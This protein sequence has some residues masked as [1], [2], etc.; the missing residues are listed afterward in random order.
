MIRFIHCADICLDAPLGIGDAKK[1]AIRRDE[2]RSSFSKVLSEAAENCVSFVLISGGLFD[3]N[4]VSKTTVDFLCAEFSRS[5][6]IKFIIAPGK[7]DYYGEDSIYRTAAFPENVHIFNKE[8][9]STL[10]FDI[11]DDRVSVHGCAKASPTAVCS[12]ERFRIPSS[13]DINILVSEALI[14]PENTGALTAQKLEAAGFD[15]CALSHP[16]A[17]VG[18][19]DEGDMWY[20]Y[21]GA[22]ES[23]SFEGMNDGGY[24]LVDAQKNG[25]D[26]TCKAKVVRV[27]N[28]KY[29]NES[30]SVSGALS[31]DEVVSTVEKSLEGIKDSVDSN[32]VLA[33]TVK[34]NTA[35]D[36]RDFTA[37][38]SELE[39]F[40]KAF[41]ASVTDE[42]VPLYN[43]EYLSEDPTIKGALYN[44]LR[45]AICSD[46]AQV[47]RNAI[48]ALRAGL[49]ALDNKALSVK[50]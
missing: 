35:P 36:V 19:F 30:I 14:T 31:T 41:I 27:T 22:P 37:K 2:M 25:K 15:Y 18:V 7:L 39:V 45:P 48:N 24:V 34:G 1:A 12:V 26:F 32:T 47:S 9:M 13:T 5:P 23:V 38:V 42:T 40:K 43:H 20:A 11:G 10:S 50:N 29:L 46:D 16:D 49:D 33:V 8:E 4:N 21:P 44:A 17:P 28:K 3:G 6:D